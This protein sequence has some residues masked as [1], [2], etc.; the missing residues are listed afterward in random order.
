MTLYYAFTDIRNTPTRTTLLCDDTRIYADARLS[1]YQVYEIALQN[2]MH[3]ANKLMLK[4]K[5]RRAT[6][7]ESRCYQE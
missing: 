3:V 1:G 6:P 2:H 5:F 4:G 7:G